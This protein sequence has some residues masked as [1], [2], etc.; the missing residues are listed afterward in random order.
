MPLREYG[1]QNEDCGNVIEVI[2]SHTDTEPTHCD[3]CGKD[4]LVR[5]ISRT[6]PPIFN[7]TGWY[8]TDYGKGKKP[9]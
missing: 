3:E 7:G 1:C 2:L 8:V 6:S 9:E 4:S 5:L